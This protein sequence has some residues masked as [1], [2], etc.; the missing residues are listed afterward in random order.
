[1]PVENVSDPYTLEVSFYTPGESVEVEPNNS[2]SDGLDIAAGKSITGHLDRRAD[3]DVFVFRGDSGKYT[4]KIDGA[5]K[6]P[7]QWQ[8][9][10][11]T[12]Q[13]ARE[14]SV[15]LNNGDTISLRRKDAKL[16]PG[17]LLPGVRSPYTLSL[18]R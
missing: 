5:K 17:S 9:N 6:V 3:V 10:E 7:V 12:S 2:R 4:L 18:R 11:G 15:T 1:M 14:K 13:D 8:I 16:A